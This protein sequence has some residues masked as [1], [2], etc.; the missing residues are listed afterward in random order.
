M[1]TELCRDTCP[2]ASQ[3]YFLVMACYS[4]KIGGVYIPTTADTI[5][6]WLIQGHSEIDNVAD[7]HSRFY[8]EL[9]ALRFS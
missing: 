8:Q 9:H 1:A 4:I 5:G 3:T 2:D 6:A 7:Q